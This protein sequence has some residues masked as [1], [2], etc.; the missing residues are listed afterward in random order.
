[1]PI[2]IELLA[3][4]RNADT[5]LHAIACGADAVYIAGPSHG[6]RAAAANSVADVT[7][8]VASAHRFGVKVYVTLNTIVFDHEISTVEQLI[9]DL[10]R[11]GVD[12]LIIQD[13]GILRMNIPP[14]RLHAS[15]QCDIRTPE[16]ARFLADA[17]MSQLV[18]A[19]ELTIREM[20]RIHE[21]VPA[22]PLEAFIHGALCVSYSGNCQAGYALARRSA[23]RGECPQIC[24]LPFT[25]IDGNGRTVMRDKHLL[26][27]RDLNR[28]AH[29][30]QM[31][32]A[33]ITSFK[34]E[35]RLKDDT[36]V[37]NVTAAY[38]RMLD[39]I[40]AAH[41]DRYSRTSAGHSAISFVPSL[42]RAFNRGFTSYFTSGV[43]PAKKMASP[44]T[45]KFVGPIVATVT[46]ASGCRITVNASVPLAN[47][48]GLCYFDSSNKLRGL[49]VNRVDGA[50]IHLAAP[51]DIPRGTALMRNFD[52]RFADTMS[53]ATAIRK[54]CATIELRTFPHGIVMTMTDEL[55]N[56]VSAT[57][58]GEFDTA[59]TPQEATRRKIVTKLGDTPFE[60]D[61]IIDT[62]GDIFVPAAQLTSLRRHTAE[63]LEAA[64]RV[65][66]RFEYRTTEAK[67]AFSPGELTYHDN[68][69]NH[70]A[71][72][73][74]A[75]LGAVVGQRAL[76]TSE[77]LPAG[78]TTVMTSRYCL[79][80]EL[81]AC[82]HP[83]SADGPQRRIPEP[84][85]LVNYPS[86]S[87]SRPIKLYPEFDC[88][89]C[90]MTISI[91]APGQS[92]RQ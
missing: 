16:K 46:A 20:E 89:Q 39:D 40:I 60:S 50:V 7:R 12:A 25:L 69:A 36:Y 88:R 18:L 3:P 4:A 80:R 44:D 52:K 15:T 5:A 90:R 64:G 21:T 42:E 17:G 22:T 73:F 63:L 57:L 48:D 75:D 27:L 81:G 78:L 8:V 58:R 62:L 6:A 14:I 84:L 11:A 33:G 70:L 54:L 24:R 32:E 91:K 10:Y 83:R 71:A 43:R 31:I 56:R 92:P 74:Y 85:T 79:R 37:M 13:L 68:V 26:S 65:R 28:S 77:T 66:Y 76:E 49:R 1:M 55:G 45:P 61:E 53:T 9:R 34:I 82:L 87:G 86:E 41:P 67:S 51:A 35:G 30:L 2:G 19:R 72:E 23:N 29:L 59:R 47:G 38:R